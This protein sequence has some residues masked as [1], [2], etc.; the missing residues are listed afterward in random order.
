M[1]YMAAILAFALVVSTVR[2]EA[3]T[4]VQEIADQIGYKPHQMKTCA[5]W[6]NEAGCTTKSEILP[7][8][9]MY[10]MAS[11]P[12]NCREGFSSFMN[13]MKAREK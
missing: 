11:V 4:G 2:A 5:F 6:A 7:S 10:R 1:R 8:Q 9:P 12:Q 3:P 13:T